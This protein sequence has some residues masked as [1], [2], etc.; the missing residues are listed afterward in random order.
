MTTMPDSIADDPSP[1]EIRLANDRMTASGVF[2]RSR[3][4]GASP[5]F[6]VTNQDE[7][8]KGQAMSN[9]NG[10]TCRA[11]ERVVWLD[12]TNVPA[13]A[14]VEKVLSIE[15]VAEM[16]AVSPWVLR[17]YEFRGLIRRRQTL[18]NTRV[19]GWADCDRIAFIIKCRRAGLRYS[20]I[21]PILR[22]TDHDSALVHE[23]AEEL[24]TTLVERLE[25]QRR[26][27]DEALSELGHIRSLL[28]A[29]GEDDS[30]A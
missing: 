13:G 29:K 20:E 14:P 3:Q 12:D 25:W 5:R 11:Q 8:R 27:I 9:G 15:N 4:P 28:G 6:V 10:P 1:D 21:V 23:S 7:S 24:C 30:G 18:G 17:H 19:Y 26:G 16:F 2:S 22:A